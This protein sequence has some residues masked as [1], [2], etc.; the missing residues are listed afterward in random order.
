MAVGTDGWPLERMGEGLC[1]AYAL[2]IGELGAI[3]Y[4]AKFDG[5]DG[6]A[7]KD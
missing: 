7:R 6:Q 1:R 3:L 2:P 4:M 5:L